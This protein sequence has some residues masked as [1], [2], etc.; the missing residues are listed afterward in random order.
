MRNLEGL[1]KKEKKKFP[2]KGGEGGGIFFSK[3]RGP[4]KKIKIFPKKKLFK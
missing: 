3:F 2:K 1:K 4:P